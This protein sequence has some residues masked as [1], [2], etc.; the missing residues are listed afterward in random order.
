MHHR[1]SGAGKPTLIRCLNRLEEPTEGRIIIEGTDITLLDK[2]ELRAKRKYGD[3][4]S[5]F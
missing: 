2:K 5:A 1:L 3:D 4:F